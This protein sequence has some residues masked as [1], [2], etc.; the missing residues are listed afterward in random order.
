MSPAMMIEALERMLLIRAHEEAAAALQKSGRAPA[1]CTA[2]GGEAS[3]VGV[4]SALSSEDEIVINH[5]SAG[6][7]ARRR[8]APHP[9]RDHGPAGRLLPPPKRLVAHLGEG[10]G[11]PADL[12]HRRR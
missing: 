7:S 2:V 1:T 11:G 8:P 5:R 12:N 3:A 9:G 6:H 4:I 10:I